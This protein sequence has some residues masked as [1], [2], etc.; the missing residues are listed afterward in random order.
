M[1]N[2]VVLSFMPISGL[3]WPQD[4]SLLDETMHSANLITT[5]EKDFVLLQKHSW[6]LTIF[7]SE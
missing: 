3:S 1:S 7:Y 6:M 4:T 5:T 2:L